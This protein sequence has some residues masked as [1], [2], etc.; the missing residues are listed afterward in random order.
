[1]ALLCARGAPP[2]ET[3]VWDP[4]ELWDYALHRLRPGVVGADAAH[5]RRRR[6]RRRGAGLPRGRRDVL[7]EPE[8]V[9]RVV[10]GLDRREPVP[11]RA[12]VG[13][14]DALLALVAEEAGVR[15]RVA[16]AQLAREA[17]DPRLRGS[18][19]PRGAA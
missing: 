13:R 11:R 12:R 1:M 10:A 17:G 18:A 4:A 7:V 9:V 3:A 5:H 14:A 16:L 6:R 8:D 2:G 19:A 15:G